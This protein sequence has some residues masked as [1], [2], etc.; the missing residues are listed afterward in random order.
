MIRNWN[1]GR[2]FSRME[3]ACV[4]TGILGFP[5]AED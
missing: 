1:T 2:F 4:E 3:T 5:D